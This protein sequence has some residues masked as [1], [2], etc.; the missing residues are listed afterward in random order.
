MVSLLVA[1]ALLS[2]SPS[3]AQTPAAPIDAATVKVGP[4]VTVGELD[5]RKLKGELQRLA[6]SADGSEL[7]VQTVDGAPPSEK[8]HHFLV[9]AAGGSLTSIDFQPEWADEYW[10]AKSDRT[11][12]TDPALMIDVKQTSEVLKYGTGSAG[13]ADGGDRAGGGTVMSGN[14]IDREAQSQKQRVVRLVVLDEV[15]SE[16]VDQRPVPGLMFGWAPEGMGAIAYTD[17]EGR[18]ILLDL[19]RHKQ[20]VSGVK[21]ALLPAWSP[22]GDRLAYVRKAGRKKYTLVWSKVDR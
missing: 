9:P 15:V 4:P 10:R 11:S 18:L 14:N 20:T 2:S 3:A 13:A 5:L 8:Q 6:W 22:D 12:P 21:D 7:Y 1:W 16:F 19:R 17:R